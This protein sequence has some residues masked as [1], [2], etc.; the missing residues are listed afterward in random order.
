MRAGHLGVHSVSAVAVIAMSLAPHEIDEAPAR[1]RLC[2]LG[3]H[4]G[5]DH[6]FLMRPVLLLFVSPSALH[7]CIEKLSCLAIGDDNALCA[8]CFLLIER[9]GW[10]GE[11]EREREREKEKERE[12]DRERERERETLAR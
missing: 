12:R 6:R 5:A 3:R 11:R 2:H 4:Y 8:L 10:G 7:A 1:R 9:E